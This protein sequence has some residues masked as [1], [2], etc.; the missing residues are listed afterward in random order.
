MSKII[1][2]NNH[3]LIEDAYGTGTSFNIFRR[4]RAQAGGIVRVFYRSAY[5]IKGAEAYYNYL[6]IKKSDRTTN[7]IRNS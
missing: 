1:A 6:T 2:Q 5:T 7:I 4:Y 3:A